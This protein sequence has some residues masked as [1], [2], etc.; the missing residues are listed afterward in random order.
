MEERVVPYGGTVEAS[1]S[2]NGGFK[3]SVTIPLNIREKEETETLAAGLF[4][5]ANK[6]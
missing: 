5:A 6:G 2:V 3:L 1:A 4:T